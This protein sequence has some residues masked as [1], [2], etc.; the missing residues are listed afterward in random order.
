MGK[1][2]KKEIVRRIIFYVS[3]IV[4]VVCAVK[5]FGIFKGYY[6]NKKSYDIVRQYAPQETHPSEESGNNSDNN[7]AKTKPLFVFSKENY[8]KLLSIN[9]DFKAWLYIP[10]TEISY[11]VVQTTDNDYYLTHNFD[12]EK[13]SGGAIFISSNNEKPF[14]DE[15]TIIH[16]HHMRDG[17]MFASLMNFKEES[18]A[19]NTPI[20]V[21]TKDKL[22]QYEVF[23]VF[24]ETANNDSYQNGFASEAEFLSYANTL[25]SKSM[26]NLGRDLTATDKIITLSTC[27]YDV[28]DGRLLVCAKL[29]SSKD[30]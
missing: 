15:N 21:N 1:I 12:K 28:D 6:D 23:S 17:S 19:K 7:V 26:F 20:Y 3:L 8:D 4:F 29:V 11:P 25:K 9:S 18:F 22:L 10:D 5:L 13:N 16:G 2:S 30:Y 24:Y 14:E 27:D